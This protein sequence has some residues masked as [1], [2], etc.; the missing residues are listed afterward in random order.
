MNNKKI[1]KNCRELRNLCFKKKKRFKHERLGWNLRMTNI[2]A[3][4]GL[5]Q[6]ERLDKFIKKKR[7]IGAKYRKLLAD[8]PGIIQPLER[9]DYAENIYWIY[10]IILDKSIKF[11]ADYA[12]KKLHQI[13]VGARCF[14]FPLHQQPILKKLGFFKNQKFPVADMLSKRGF[15]I[16][17]GIGLTDFQIKSV[18]KKLKKIIKLK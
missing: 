18:A 9:T 3:A 12:I 15:Y 13:G 7:L 1:E 2:Q 10:G 4:L 8:L 11:N 17:S 14:F 5:A 16:P 6:L